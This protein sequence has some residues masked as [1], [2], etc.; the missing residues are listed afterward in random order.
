MTDRKITELTAL[1]TVDAADVLA[2]VDDPAGTPVTKKI[3]VANLTA[4]AQPLDAELTA[5]AGLTS[6]ADK[7]P[8][9]TGSGTAAVTDLSSFIRTLLDDADAAAAQATLGAI[10]TSLL[11]TRGDLIRRGA[12]APERVA[13]GAATALLRSDGTDAVWG[14]AGQIPFPAA[15][16]ASADPNTLDDYEEGTW[17]PA[18]TFDTA[19]DLSVTYGTQD[20]FYE[21]VGRLVIARFRIATTAFT[22]TTASGSFRITG[23]PFTGVTG[24]ATHVGI[25]A[26]YR[27][28]TKAN[29]TM[30]SPRINA[31][32]GTFTQIQA[33][34][35]AQTPTGV[36]VADVPTGGTV[37]LSGSLIYHTT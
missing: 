8:Y 30:Y 34:G 33:S 7:L 19:G 10:A 27:G 14:S 4:G 15:Q 20:G 32:S 35:S 18:V 22:H 12:S 17:T 2:I 13:L 29:F 5:L 16:N 37:E 25:L 23:Q 31:T 28:I 24:I 3:T 11:T 9:F 21:R 36:V 26:I 6:A 1:E